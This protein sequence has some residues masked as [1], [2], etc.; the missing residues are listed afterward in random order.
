MRALEESILKKKIL[1]SWTAALCLLALTAFP[2][3]AE[4]SA[5]ADGL[6]AEAVGIADNLFS[7]IFGA[8]LSF[9]SAYRALLD[10]WGLGVCYFVLP[11]L[12]LL[13]LSLFGYRLSRLISV[14]LSAGIGF[15][16]G[17]VGLEFAANAFVLPSWLES[18]LPIGKWV[19]A[20]IVAI[21]L[22]LIAL[23]LRRVGLALILASTVTLLLAGYTA[24]L[25]LL[26]SVLA[27][28]FVF[29]LIAMKPLV[30]YITSLSGS[31]ALVRLLFRSG[32]AF[33]FDLS[34]T[35]GIVGLDAWLAVG[36]ILGFLCILF[37]EH[38]SKNRRYC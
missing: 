23:W 11:A 6:A 3:G 4:S 27:V 2:C 28:S 35:L 29:A 20:A 13:V 37:Q 22:L 12:L 10:A 9:W 38:F 36:L 31:F 5:P 1:L 18:F 19:A 33:S 32:G 8:L 16:V 24:N 30:I 15:C 14:V 7:M 26:L 17:Y 34:A 21:V 25:T